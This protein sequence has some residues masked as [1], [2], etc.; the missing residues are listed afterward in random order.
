MKDYDPNHSIGFNLYD[1]ARLLG[2]EFERRA[3]PHGV[4]RVQWRVLVW[5]AAQPGLRQAQLAGL[6]EVT[7]IAVARLIDRM[8]DEGLIERHPDPDDRR[9]W[10]L[11]LTAR[12]QSRMDT[13]QA[14]A[15]DVRAVALA[16]LNRKEQEFLLDALRRIRGNLAA[17]D[18]GDHVISEKS[19]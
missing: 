4:T 15:A 8:E 2:N 12:A 14:I 10:R 18:S 3:R 7:P 16:G 19:R 5:L 1:A 11:K 17:S 13:M 9:A 6:L